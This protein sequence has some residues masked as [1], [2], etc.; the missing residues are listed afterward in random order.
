MDDLYDRL[1][2]T[3]HELAE[4]TGRSG[5]DIVVV[6][7]SGLGGY[8]ARHP[9]AAA[10]PYQRLSGFPIPRAAGHTAAAYSLEIGGNRILLYAGR[11]H[12]YEGHPMDVITYPVRTAVIAG[13][14][15]VVLT[16][17]AGGCGD[18]INAGD[19]V[20]I[21]DHINMSGVSPLAG[22]NDDR[23]GP[24]FPD[25]TD[26]YTPALRNQAHAAAAATGLDLKEGVYF[27]WHGPMY[28]TPAEVEMA[29]RLG[30]SL[31]GMS[32]VPEATA[33][34]HMGAGVLGL[35]LCTNLA[36]GIARHR[37]SSEEVTT[38]AAAAGERLGRFLD[39]LLERL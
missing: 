8:T 24:R 2:A 26:V 12:A 25:M 32:T 36:A 21:T 38:T 34:R 6:L 3:A 18:G 5:H 29:R 7:G 39:V 30:A 17:A 35:S 4:A 23:L 20:A 27:W 15:T 19:V 10:V 11:A 22:P 37:L 9:S 31:V 1:V 33:A 28:E 13:C 14:R 16:N